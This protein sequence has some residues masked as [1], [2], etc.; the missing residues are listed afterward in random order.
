[1]R[2]PGSWHQDLGGAGVL[3]HHGQDQ[4][5]PGEHLRRREDPVEGPGTRQD[6]ALPRWR[7]PG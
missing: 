5:G 1:M 7:A 3:Q 6:S 2:S 4:E